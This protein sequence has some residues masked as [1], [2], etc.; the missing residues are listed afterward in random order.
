MKSPY[1][2]SIM[3]LEGIK[4]ILESLEGRH[5][6]KITIGILHDVKN[7]IGSLITRLETNS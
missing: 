6:Q 3:Y 5:D 4:V 7:K 2:E 1:Q